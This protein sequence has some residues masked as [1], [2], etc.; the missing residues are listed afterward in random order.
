[1]S[2]HLPLAYA[3][4]VLTTPRNPRLTPGS[5]CFRSLRELGSKST[6]RIRSGACIFT[7]SFLALFMFPSVSDA[8]PVRR[9]YFEEFLEKRL[10][11]SA[12][13]KWDPQKFCPTSTSLVARRVIE[14]YGA[15]FAATESVMLP[16]V[17]VFLGEP[18]VKA[19]QKQLNTDRIEVGSATL[20]FQKRAADSLRAAMDE[21]AIERLRITPLDGIVAGGRTFGDTL[22]LW[23]SRVFRGLEHWQRRGRLNTT[24]I[25]QFI[26]LEPPQRVERILEWETT[27]IFFDTSR[28]R[29]ILTSTAAPGSSQHLSYI[30][31]DVVEHWNPKVRSILNRHGWYQTVLDDPPHFTFLGSPESELPSRGLQMIAKGGHFYWVPNFAPQTTPPPTN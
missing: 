29:S 12:P 10:G 4:S 6:W 19:F 27:G 13:N 7:L 5:K 24:D 11:G 1:M 25:D 16:P 28:T 8:Q 23:N 31:L 15:M 3:S 22:M 14:S 20:E 30:A 17:C 9:V 18:D 2:K 21:L 26:R